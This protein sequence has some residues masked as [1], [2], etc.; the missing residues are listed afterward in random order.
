MRTSI[1]NAHVLSMLLALSIP[2]ITFA[3]G[4]HHDHSP[5][6]ACEW[7]GA[8][9]APRNLGSTLIVAGTDEPGE[10]LIVTGT[11]YSPD[12]RTPARDILIYA[13]HTDAA[14][15]YP[16]RGSET[17]N[18]RRHGYLRGWLRTDASGRYRIETIRPGSYPGRSDPAH[19]HM[20]LTPPGRD[21]FWI[22]AFEF[23]DDPRL[24][25]AERARREG[26]GGSGI[27]TPR[28][29][30]EGVWHATRNIALPR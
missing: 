13:Y 17:G 2:G 16:K 11:V 21:E 7:C 22:D 29:D 28:R 15:I 27:V 14:G 10:R 25:P 19:I 3:G 23:D 20:T 4:S 6:P 12:G 18:G 8:A 30:D 1:V 26:R 24:T 5:L 9:E